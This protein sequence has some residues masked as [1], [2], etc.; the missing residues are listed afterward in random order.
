MTK[1]KII[2]CFN[3]K[4]ALGKDGKLLYHIENDLE[5]FKRMTLDNVVIMG[6]STYESLP[7]GEP[8]SDR[9]N[10]VITSNQE[11]CVDCNYENVYIVHSIEDA[12]DLCEA[13][14]SDKEVFVIG[15]GRIYRE[16]LEK[17]L[18]NEMRLTIVDDEEEGDVKF[19]EFDETEWYA[20]YK[21]MT[22]VSSEKSFY[23][24]VLQKV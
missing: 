9:I 12:V 8:L 4:R 17:G 15:G 19:P 18:V 2:A 7:N 6:R 13:L 22:Q 1:F 24:E 16:F 5:N 11:Y 3:K 10:V 14:F 21:T 20:Y 23:F